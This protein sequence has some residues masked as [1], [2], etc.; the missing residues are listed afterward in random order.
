MKV[1]ENNYKYLEEINIINKL[2]TSIKN[3]IKQIEEYKEIKNQY[4]L[5]KVEINDINKLIIGKEQ[6]LQ[7]KNDRLTNENLNLE[8]SKEEKN[9]KLMEKSNFENLKSNKEEISNI[10]KQEISN[11]KNKEE[12]IRKLE[13][14]LEISKNQNE[15]KNLLEIITKKRTEKEKIRMQINELENIKLNIANKKDIQI[16]ENANNIEISENE[17]EIQLLEDEIKSKENSIEDLIHQENKLD[18]LINDYEKDYNLKLSNFN[19]SQDKIKIIYDNIIKEKSELKLLKEK[20]IENEKNLKEMNAK[21]QEYNKKLEEIEELEKKII[22]NKNAIEYNKKKFKENIQTEKEKKEK[23]QLA[24]NKQFSEFNTNF[25]ILN[26]NCKLFKKE[27]NNAKT[28]CISK[29]KEY[30]NSIKQSLKERIIKNIN[31]LMDKD[32]NNIFNYY[33]DLLKKLKKFNNDDIILLKSSTKDEYFEF[34]IET[35]QF[36]N[37]N[38][39]HYLYIYDL[40]GNIFSYEYSAEIEDSFYLEESIFGPKLKNE[41]QC[42]YIVYSYNEYYYYNNY[43]NTNNYFNKTIKSEYYENKEASY[44]KNIIYKFDHSKFDNFIYNSINEKTKSFD[45]EKEL[46]RLKFGEDNFEIS[47]NSFY[48]KINDIIL[49]INKLNTFLILLE[50]DKNNKNFH[51]LIE[52]LKKDANN[53]RILFDIN[54]DICTF[55]KYLISK[56]NNRKY[57]CPRLNEELNKIN[58]KFICYFKLI[59]SFNDLLTNNNIFKK[60]YNLKIVLESTNILI[61]NYFHLY[62]PDKY[63]QNINKTI[64]LNDLNINS[65]LLKLPIISKDN[66]ILSCTYETIEE[67]FPPFITSLY[68]DPIKINFLSLVNDLA[69]ELTDI[70]EE[71][72]KQC[73]DYEIDNNQG[74][75]KLFITIPKLENNENEKESH[76][77]KLIINFKSPSCND[78]CKIRC[79]FEFDIIPFYVMVYCEEYELIKMNDNETCLNVTQL[80]FDDEL[81]FKI[82]NYINDSPVNYK[83]EIKYLENNDYEGLKKENIKINENEF[84]LKLKGD[85]GDNNLEQNK[86]ISILIIIYFNNNLKINIK[87]DSLIS[88]FNFQILCYDYENKKFSKSININ[89]GSGKIFKLIDQ[90]NNSNNFD[91]YSLENIIY[92]DK[93]TLYFK[94]L[95]PIYDNLNCEV[96]LIPSQSKYFVIKNLQIKKYIQGNFNFQFD[97]FIDKSIVKSSQEFLIEDEYSFTLRINNVEKKYEILAS[98]QRLSSLRDFNKYKL[99]CIDIDD[100]NLLQKEIFNKNDFYNYALKGHSF[101]SQF[102]EMGG[103]EIDYKAN[104][105]TKIKVSQKMKCLYLDISGIFGMR[106][107][108]IFN[109]TTKE[110]PYNRINIFGV[111]EDRPKIWCPLYCKYDNEIECL[112]MKSSLYGTEE[113]YKP[114]I[115]EIENKFKNSEDNNFNKFAYKLSSIVIALFNSYNYKNKFLI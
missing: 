66:N 63:I 23:L 20:K 17:N 106:E 86:R 85:K 5:T 68:Q 22:E 98:Y 1:F 43:Y 47:E 79:K 75:V 54:S 67:K 46:P 35:K 73:L 40:Y 48:V 6:Q 24:A 92:P 32:I 105:I 29:I 102:G 109:E 45:P 61:P 83:L 88:Y 74:I 58:D 91:D 76:V 11:I 80:F 96:K 49:T 65:D 59:T 72:Y 108:K 115:L 93:I 41:F 89:I 62:I 42:E 31:A 51:K 99:I 57:E 10:L 21:I 7:K 34:H 33:D 19:D 114:I 15:L 9:E 12:E 113:E 84:S 110:I 50:E 18:K 39:K 38:E 90:N 44:E 100:D 13:E 4:Y 81:H 69:L 71:K 82:K 111:V 77:I 37:K 94:V 64:N 101:I 2:K 30:K 25:N 28:Q 27:F 78:V 26:N 60:A 87:I 8:K 52:E 103:I 112:F 14:N 70:N 56:F 55:T 16:R 53:I 95:I 97:L 104:S 3:I 107:W 36:H